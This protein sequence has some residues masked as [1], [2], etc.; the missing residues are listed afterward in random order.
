MEPTGDK[1]TGGRQ[2]GK[3]I[4]GV[5]ILLAGMAL[6]GL[7]TGFLPFYFKHILFSW[8]MI[9][10]IIG[11]IF[12]LTH[13]NKTP[14]LIMLAIGSFFILPR[15]FDFPFNFY[16]ML[17]PLVLIIIGLIILFRRGHMPSF[18]MPGQKSETP[19][20]PDTGY[21]HEESVFTGTRHK[22]FYQTFRGGY[23]NCV[24]GSVDLDLSQA[25]LG[26]GTTELELNIVFGG[27][28]LIVPS[29][30]KLLVR[31]NSVVGN[32]TDKRMIIKESS[33][34]SKMLI[35]KGSIVFGGG[36]IKSY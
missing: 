34:P 23:I 28:N 13:D 33:D 32:F 25:T 16:G 10:I 22:F 31:T 36:E 11:I 26:E 4:L 5:I 17:W 24:F 30:W 1:N 21:I 2:S 3:F 20:P 14:G 29:D 18:H 27:V 19:P 12:L 15:V 35:I 7:N 8:Q 6:L 9:L